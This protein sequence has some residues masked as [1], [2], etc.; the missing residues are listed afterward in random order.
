MELCAY[1][2]SVATTVDHV[3]A[4]SL[5][6][7][8]AP[9]DRPAVACCDRCNNQASA[10]DEYFRDSIL[11]YHRVADRPEVQPLV[12]KMIRALRKPKKKRYAAATMQSMTEFRA[13]TTAG[14]DLGVQP[15]FRVN[16]DRLNRTVER[17]VR[18]LHLFELGIRLPPERTVVANANPEGVIAEQDRLASLLAQGHSRVIKAGIFWYKWVHP[19]DQPTASFWL[20]TFFDSFPAIAGVRPASEPNVAA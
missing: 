20:L 9:A 18:G 8:V 2:P 13:I 19:S 16:A 3:P 4:Q 5:L 12:A 7:G 1:C 6:V 10:D 17:Y 11:K 15:A 14:L